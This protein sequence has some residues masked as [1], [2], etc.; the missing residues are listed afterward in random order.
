MLSFTASTQLHMFSPSRK[1]TQCLKYPVTKLNRAHVIVHFYNPG[2]YSKMTNK[3]GEVNRVQLHGKAGAIIFIFFVL[4]AR[5]WGA[6]S[7]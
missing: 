5:G 4:L 1:D 7:N 3:E 6:D 2:K